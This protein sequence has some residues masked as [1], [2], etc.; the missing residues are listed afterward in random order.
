MRR[1]VVSQRPRVPDHQL[2]VVG[3]RSKEGLVQKMPSDVLY[4]GSMAGE[5]RLGVNALKRSRRNEN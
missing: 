3:D 5:D 1:L 4:D 2:L